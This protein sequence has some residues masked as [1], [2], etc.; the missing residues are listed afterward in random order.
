MVVEIAHG[1]CTDVRSVPAPT[2][3]SAAHYLWAVLI[4]R[5]YVFPLLCPMCGGQMRIITFIRHSA[6]IR[7]MLD[8]IGVQAEPPCIFPARGPPLWGTVMRRRI[9]VP[10]R[11]R[12]G[13]DGATV[14]GLRGR[15][16]RQ[17]MMV[18][19]GDSD[20]LRRR[21]ACATG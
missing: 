9:K 21:A 4:A 10:S 15:S 18:R 3:S 14:T 13:F 16:A 20:P 7:Q 12:L 8:H 19:N 11:S 5:I 2:K 6:D 1:S 17:V